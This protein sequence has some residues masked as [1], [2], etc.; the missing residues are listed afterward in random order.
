[1]YSDAS[2]SLL[3]VVEEENELEGVAV[4]SISFDKLSEQER[5]L[6]RHRELFLSRQIETYKIDMV[7]W[8]FPV[9]CTIVCSN[10]GTAHSGKCSVTLLNE[11]E[12]V[13]TYLEKEDTFFYSMV[14]DPNQKTLLVDKGEIRIG[15]DYQAEIPAYISPGIAPY[16]L[17]MIQCECRSVSSQSPEKTHPTWLPRCGNL[18]RCQI[19]KWNSF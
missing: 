4:S 2:F 8:V 13:R 11:L 6:V 16:T 3:V 19:T 15:A 14:Y 12:D 5:H 17:F 18:I 9:S 1:M 10:E 7:R